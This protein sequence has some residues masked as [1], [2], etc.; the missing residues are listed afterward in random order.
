MRSPSSAFVALRAAQENQVA[1]HS[2]KS[3]QMY[4][5]ILSNLQPTGSA[6]ALSQPLASESWDWEKRE[7]LNCFARFFSRKQLA[8]RE[9]SRRTQS[10]LTHIRWPET[11]SRA[12]WAHRWFQQHGRLRHSCRNASFLCLHWRAS[13]QGAEA[14]QPPMRL[15]LLGKMRKEYLQRFQNSDNL[16]P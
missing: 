5:F 14:Y 12:S 4:L 9:K 13:V 10:G 2:L 15:M 1:G 11:G 7:L 8:P 6:G 3:E 16:E